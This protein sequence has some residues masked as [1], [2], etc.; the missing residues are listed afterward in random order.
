[1][2]SS[3]LLIP[4][5]QGGVPDAVDSAFQL[6]GDHRITVVP[7]TV[8][9]V[10]VDRSVR[11]LEAANPWRPCNVSKANGC[12]T[13]QH[14]PPKTTLIYSAKVLPSNR[15]SNNLEAWRHSQVSKPR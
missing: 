4:P 14:A 9:R 12:T 10:L 8:V 2:T 7:G 6:T 3:G 1:M 5:D 11:S 13:A 15:C